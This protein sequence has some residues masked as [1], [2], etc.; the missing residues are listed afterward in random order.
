MKQTTETKNRYEYTETE[1]I[2]LLNLKG[3]RISIIHQETIE[4]NV[5]IKTSE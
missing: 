2:N 3:T 1:L 4:G 5:I